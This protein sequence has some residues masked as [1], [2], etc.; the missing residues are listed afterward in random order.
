MYGATLNFVKKLFYDLKTT[1]HRSYYVVLLFVIIF[2]FAYYF[3]ALYTTISATQSTGLCFHFLNCSLVSWSYTDSK[4]LRNLL[5]NSLQTAFNNIYIVL[6][7]NVVC[8]FYTSL[9]KKNVLVVVYNS[10]YYWFKY[11]I[12]NIILLLPIG[13]FWDYLITHIH[14]CTS[15]HLLR[16]NSVPIGCIHKKYTLW[17]SCV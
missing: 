12:Y 9:I 6:T 15:Y 7:G 14:T 3:D 11:Y 4:S 1:H 8:L 2:N 16:I 13:R 5:E 10:I 17:I